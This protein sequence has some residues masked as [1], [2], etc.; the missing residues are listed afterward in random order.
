MPLSIF[1]TNVINILHCKITTIKNQDQEKHLGAN[2][3]QRRQWN[4]RHRAS[5]SNRRSRKGLLWFYFPNSMNHHLL[6]Q[7]DVMHRKDTIIPVYKTQ[8]KVTLGQVVMPGVVRVY[9]GLNGG[10]AK[11]TMNSKTKNWIR[12]DLDKLLPDIKASLQSIPK[13]QNSIFPSQFNFYKF[14][15]K[16][17]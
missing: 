10:G 11:E 15:W 17:L 8:V 12:A 2:V 5:A 9:S 16:I 14:F 7:R 3:F 1:L 13:N 6:L 4:W